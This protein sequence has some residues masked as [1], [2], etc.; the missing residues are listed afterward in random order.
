MTGLTNDKGFASSLEHDLCPLWSLFPHV[1]KISKFGPNAQHVASKV[2]S[3]IKA[4]LLKQ[5]NLF[6]SL[7]FRYFGPVDGHDVNHLVAVMNDLK[8]LQG[9]WYRVE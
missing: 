9:D 8:K 2:E 3:G 5:S 7:K 1:G 4:T 6:E